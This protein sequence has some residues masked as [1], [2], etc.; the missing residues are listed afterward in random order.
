[1]V[2]L[3]RLFGTSTWRHGMICFQDWVNLKEAALTPTHTDTY[4][5]QTSTHH[6]TY[7]HTYVH[8]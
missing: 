5:A 2:A 4:I 8:T 6:S 3:A 1:M 7:I